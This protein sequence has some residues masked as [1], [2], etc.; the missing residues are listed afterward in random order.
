MGVAVGNGDG[1]DY[2]GAKGGGTVC[3]EIEVDEDF[4]SPILEDLGDTKR[5]L[6]G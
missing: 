2:K 4:S 6:A 1:V 3:E 5:T